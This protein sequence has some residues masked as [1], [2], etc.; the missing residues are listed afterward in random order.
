M[1]EWE[2][3]WDEILRRCHHCGKRKVDGVHHVCAVGTAA[4]CEY[5]YYPMVIEEWTVMF[6]FECEQDRSHNS[7]GLDITQ[8]NPL[9]ELPPYGGTMDEQETVITGMVTAT[10]YLMRIAWLTV[11]TAYGDKQALLT[12]SDTQDFRCIYGSLK[13][14]DDVSVTGQVGHAA[15]G[16]EIIKARLVERLWQEE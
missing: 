12:A 8:V 2:R 11:R 15:G 3:E 6:C 13:V 14:G 16:G 1:T 7:A 5:C 10:R 4:W 9:L